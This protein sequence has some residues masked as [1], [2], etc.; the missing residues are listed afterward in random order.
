MIIPNEVKDYI[1]SC[2][3]SELNNLKVEL[4]NNL[5]EVLNKIRELTIEINILKEGDN[6]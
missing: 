3:Q 1:K 5:N 4:S 2:V 6:I